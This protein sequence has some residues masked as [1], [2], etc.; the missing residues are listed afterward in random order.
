MSD[1]LTIKKFLDRQRKY[2]VDNQD[3]IGRQKKSSA[4]KE[5]MLLKG[6]TLICPRNRMVPPEQY[7]TILD[8]GYGD[9]SILNSLLCSNIASLSVPKEN[10]PGK[11]YKV[12]SLIDNLTKIGGESA[13]GYAMLANLRSLDPRYQDAKNLFVV[14]TP[15]NPTAESFANQTHEYFIGVFGTNTLRNHIPNFSYV[16]G[17]FDCSP[18]FIDNKDVVTFCQND[19]GSHQVRYLLYENIENS[20][21]L[22]DY[23]SNGCTL[24][25][26]LKVYI[27]I[28]LSVGQAAEKVGFTHYD[29]HTENVMVRRLDQPIQIKYRVKGKDYYLVTDRL[30]CIIDYGRSHITYE[31][32]HY[33]YYVYQLG[34]FPN[35]TFPM[36]DMFKLLSFSL[37]DALSS[38]GV[39]SQGGRY[40]IITDNDIVTMKNRQVFQGAKFLMQHFDTNYP[41]DR[42]ASYLDDAR[43]SY[44]ELPNDRQFVNDSPVS[45]VEKIMERYSNLYLVSSRQYADISLYGCANNNACLT[46]ETAL[47]NYTTDEEALLQDFYVFM[48]LVQRSSGSKRDELLEKGVKYF[49]QHIQQVY[50][51]ALTYHTRYLDLKA[52]FQPVSIYNQN[53]SEL[54]LLNLK[55][56]RD[57]VITVVGMSEEMTTLVDLRELFNEYLSWFEKQLEKDAKNQELKKYYNEKFASMTVDKG[58]VN[59]QINGLTRDAQRIKGLTSSAKRTIMNNYQGRDR[60]LLNWLFGTF[61]DFLPA[62]DPI[63]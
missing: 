14:K 38:W 54:N 56:Y 36:K 6:K 31:N 37:V 5:V 28:A 50:N 4:E 19:T 49:T 15:K 7:K 21:S 53:G 41:E 60:S 20:L 55:Q 63:R 35:L 59:Q 58:L 39:V 25:E 18:P 52:N 12:R 45:L 48:E 40:N 1:P 57:Y 46:L 17:S 23:I 10:G 8:T 43:F 26:F 62:V 33:G 27:Q 11:T 16:M 34:I 61:P 44:Y 30:A 22:S 47:R 2:A 13:E 24:E 51:D 9:A 3:L 42:T 29:L 32:E